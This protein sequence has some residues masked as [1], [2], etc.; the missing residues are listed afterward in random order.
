MLNSLVYIWANLLEECVPGVKV[1]SQ[2]NGELTKWGWFVQSSWSAMLLESRWQ[3]GQK[4][5][6]PLSH[7]FCN[8]DIH[9]SLLVFADSP[10]PGPDPSSYFAFCS[11]GHPRSWLSLLLASPTRSLICIISHWPLVS[12]P[13]QSITRLFREWSDQHVFEQ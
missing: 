5:E 10:T 9:Y 1:I 12:N 2:S 7:D 8:A 3:R 13:I 4:R 6:N 11:S